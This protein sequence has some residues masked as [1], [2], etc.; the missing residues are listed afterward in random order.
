MIRPDN[1]L[2]LILLTNFE[3]RSHFQKKILPSTDR[4]SEKLP[5][6]AI[7]AFEFRQLTF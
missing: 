1:P 5:V 4:Q 7:S 6:Y 2:H 3:E